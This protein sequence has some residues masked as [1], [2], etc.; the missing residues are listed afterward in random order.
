MG[1]N[2]I[3][4]TKWLLQRHRPDLNRSPCSLPLHIAC[5][6]GY[7]VC[8]ELL[9]KYGA[10][11]ECDSRIC[12]PASHSPNCELFQH[13]GGNHFEEVDFPISCERF[14]N[15]KLQNAICYAIDGDHINVL[16]ILV[17]KLEDP[18]VNYSL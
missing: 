16:N 18:W 13:N 15:S 14:D 9:L 11:I 5:L 3:E 6:K 7:E 12:F 17:Q 1:L 2:H 10:R 8:V 4:L